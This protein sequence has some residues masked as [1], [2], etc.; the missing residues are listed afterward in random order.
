M[1]RRAAG[2]GGPPAA[3]AHRRAWLVGERQTP[4]PFQLTPY[5]DSAKPVTMGQMW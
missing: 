4:V 3:Q 1:Y 2:T 5:P